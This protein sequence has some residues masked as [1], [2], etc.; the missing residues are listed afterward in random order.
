MLTLRLFSFRALDGSRMAVLFLYQLEQHFDPGYLGNY[1]TRASS[2]AA[3]SM[4][5]H[6]GA[7]FRSTQG[8]SCAS[9]D[10][11]RGFD[12]YVT[13]EGF[14]AWRFWVEYCQL[15]WASNS[16]YFIIRRS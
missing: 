5:H 12:W 13:A 16:S 10:P 14:V 7:Y 15:P 4:L 1:P 2:V 9:H 6:H 11:V 8:L 3:A